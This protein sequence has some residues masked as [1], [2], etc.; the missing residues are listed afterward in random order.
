MV[1]NP[2]RISIFFC[3]LR[4]FGLTFAFLL[5]ARIAYAED[6]DK[7]VLPITELKLLAL[8]IEAKFGTGFCLDS[9][10]RFVGTNY[11]VAMMG[12]PR[13][14][15]GE[16]VIRRYVATGPA[17]E[18]ATLNDGPSLS[19]SKYTLRR[20]L[21]IFEL[22]NPLR[23]YHGATFSLDDLQF[24]QQVDIYAYPKETLNPMRGIRQ[25]HGTFK[26]QTTTGLLAF[27]YGASVD[28]AIRPGASGGLVVDSKTKKI[29][30]ILNGIARNGEPI[31]LAV[32]VQALAEFV[33]EVQ[34]YLAQSIFPLSMLVSP[35]SPD[36]FS[37]FIPPHPN[38]L[39]HR[40]EEPAEVKTLRSKA[41]VL[42]DSLR[43]FIAVQN[44]AWG[45]RDDVPVAVSAYEIQVLG[46]YQRFR[47]YPEGKKQL[48]DIPFPPVNT[49]MVPGG[50]WSELPEM[51]G[52]E[53]H[54]KIHQADDTVVNGQRLRVFQYWAD[55][56]DDVCRWKSVVDLGL[57][58]VDKTVTVACYGEVW[59]DEDTNILRISEHY[60]LPGKWKNYQAVVTYGWLGRKDEISVLMPLTITTQAEYNKKTYWCRGNFTD[61]RRF[62]SES[63][64]LVK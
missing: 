21:A 7:T 38:T 5:S 14:I 16:K 15:K 62:S 20:D 17:D 8:G 30:G 43:N 22:R 52:S 32:P 25:F 53:L 51:V 31:A 59:T 60:E 2:K 33:S 49:V 55:P 9:A 18:G 46:G 12:N 28:K 47:E 3:V 4:Q 63:K 37:K 40:P 54:L 29:V 10:C 27:D 45:S 44:L 1:I 50:E 35:D 6:F 26:G 34:P 23:H 24:G 39:L 64:I 57:F 61:Y 11:H 48:R 56:E 41:Q 58:S 13:K 36:I 42:T 19:P